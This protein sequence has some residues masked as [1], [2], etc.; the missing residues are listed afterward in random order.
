M[1][2]LYTILLKNIQKKREP[3]PVKRKAQHI[4]LLE[5]AVILD[6]NIGYTK[7]YVHY[8]KYVYKNRQ[9][10]REPKPFQ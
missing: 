4:I 10:K 2:A 1:L 6:D 9:K 3:F 5:F 7:Q 8:N